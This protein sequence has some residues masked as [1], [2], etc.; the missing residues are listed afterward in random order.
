MYYLPNGTTHDFTIEYDPDSN[1]GEG[2]VTVT[3]DAQTATLNLPPGVKDTGATM[4]RFGMF[5]GQD[6]NGK[7][8]VVYF[9]D[10]EYT[11]RD[12]NAAK[13]WVF[14]E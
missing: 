4:N 11:V 6:N 12:V 3:L 13:H 2:T 9:D 14:F 1:G 7:H 5:T 8:S 10:L